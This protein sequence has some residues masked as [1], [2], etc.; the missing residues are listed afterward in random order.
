ME[1]PK[2][3][4]EAIKL[5]SDPNNAFDY[6]V[7]MRWPNGVNCPH[8][9]KA[10]GEIHSRVS[11]LTTRKIWKCKECKK[12]FSVR[13]NTIMEDSPLGLDKW[14]TAIWL[15]VSTKNGISSYE[16]ARSLGIK[17]ESAWFMMHRIRYALE[18]GSLEKMDGTIEV[19]ESM[20]GDKSKNMHADRRAAQRA[21]GFPK[22]TVMGMRQ[23]K[24]EVRTMVISNR[25]QGTLQGRI[26]ENIA[27]GST[28]YTDAW[29]SYNGLSEK[30][31]HGVV[32]HNIGQYVSGEDGEIT[33]NGMENYW[34]IL[35]RAYHGTYIHMADW[36]AH[37]YLAEE[38]FRFNTRAQKDG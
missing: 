12:Q 34:T 7:A 19:D 9:I 11:F 38:D 37:R 23:R 27:E 2:T 29:K 3:L 21:K 33:T 31:E 22:V 17:Q 1:T 8:C 6:L 32:D 25:E 26:E 24:G 14:L 28:V 16:V 13:L 36:H 5:F 18:Y 4:I 35:K 15:L 10:T 30:Y 20:L